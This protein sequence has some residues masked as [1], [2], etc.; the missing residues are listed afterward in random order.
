ME[1]VELVSRATHNMPQISR[2]GLSL[3]ADGG[4]APTLDIVF[5]HGLGGHPERTWA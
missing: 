1:Q 5:V 3:V 4:E 2:L